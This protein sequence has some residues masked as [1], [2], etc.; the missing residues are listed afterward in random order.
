MWYSFLLHVIPSRRHYG[1]VLP[2]VKYYVSCMSML[3][4]CWGIIIVVMCRLYPPMWEIRYCYGIGNVDASLWMRWEYL[5]NRSVVVLFVVV[6]ILTDI[7]PTKFCPLV[8]T[9]VW[10]H[11]CRDATEFTAIGQYATDMDA[12]AWGAAHTKKLYIH[13]RKHEQMEGYIRRW[14]TRHL[15]K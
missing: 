12:L 5:S 10:V 14:R 3:I 15:T 4:R 13:F 8:L 11:Q 6:S 1:W 7:F 9:Q 2:Q